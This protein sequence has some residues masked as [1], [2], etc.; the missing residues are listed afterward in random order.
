MAARARSI[1]VELSGVA[2]SAT[3]AGAAVGVATSGEAIEAAGAGNE[4]PGPTGPTSIGTPVPATATPAVLEEE[5]EEEQEVVL[6][7]DGDGGAAAAA[8]PSKAAHSAGDLAAFTAAMA[9]TS[10]A[11][12][13]HELPQLSRLPGPPGLPN[14]PGPP[15]L[16]GLPGLPGLPKPS[17]LKPSASAPSLKSANALGSLILGFGEAGP[18][19]IDMVRFSCLPRSAAGVFVSCGALTLP[20]CSCATSPTVDGTASE[21]CDG[22]EVLPGDRLIESVRESA[23]PPEPLEDAPCAPALSTRS[24]CSVDCDVL[25]G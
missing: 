15:S 3:A 4:W 13:A 16:P 5:K 6:C 1:D 18:R 8:L 20:P 12:L 19:R 10:A 22:C 21:L 7:A 17:S 9:A 11:R 24:A 14:L 2:T 25:I 23:L